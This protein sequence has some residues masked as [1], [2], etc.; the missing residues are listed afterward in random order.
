MPAAMPQVSAQLAQDWTAL[1]YAQLIQNL[2]ALTRLGAFEEDSL[3]SALAV[4]RLIDRGRILRSG[5]SA[6]ELRQALDR[7]RS[8]TD[9]RPIPAIERA[10][11]HAI[12]TAE[13][14][15]IEQADDEC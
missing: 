5:L 6:A 13:D 10:L 4:A 12:A 7:Y 15:L 8:G 2:N 14:A 9:W 11:E 1:N 3:A